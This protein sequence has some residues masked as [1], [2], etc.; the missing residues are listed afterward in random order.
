MSKSDLDDSGNILLDDDEKTI[1]KKILK[2]VTDSGS[3]VATGAD[4]PA[5]TNM[6][7]IM[8]VL[9]G[10]S[11]EDLELQ[12]AGRGYGEFKYTWQTWSCIPL[13]HYEKCMTSI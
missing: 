13:S 7:V 8:S 3:A 5:L 6:L 1:E 11:I 2:A 12:Y 4:K 9:G 10:K